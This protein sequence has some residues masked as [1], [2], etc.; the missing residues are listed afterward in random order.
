MQS[1]IGRLSRLRGSSE[2]R[3]QGLGFRLQGFGFRGL[4]FRVQGLVVQA[5]GVLVQGLGAENSSE[6]KARREPQE[7]SSGL[8]F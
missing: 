2:F 8:G 3:V 1:G 7:S 6:I 4:G 5:L